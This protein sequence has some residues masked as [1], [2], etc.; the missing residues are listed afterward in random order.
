[1]K[2]GILS[3][4][5]RLYTVQQLPAGKVSIMPHPRGGDWLSDEMK[6]LFFEGVDV[7]VSLLT[8]EEVAELDLQHEAT[9]CQG[10]GIVYLSYPILDLTVPPFSADTF[11]LLE[12]L[13]AYLAQ[14][15]HI[16]IHCWMGLGRSALIAASVLV[17]SG[18]TPERACKVL[19]VERGYNVPEMEEQRV[20]VRA[21]AQRY[22]E[23][24]RTQDD[25]L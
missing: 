6:A 4:F 24:L 20:W 21:L 2:E 5:A 13:K 22:Q 16:A 15:K 19:S 18:Y 9:I 12:A 11:A 7:L 1:L 10:Q 14:G 23:H 3:D 8:P 25:A 17:L